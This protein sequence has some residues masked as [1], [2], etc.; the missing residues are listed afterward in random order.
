[1]V[2]GP[3]P[4]SGRACL[5]GS[6]LDSWPGR[7]CT[8]HPPP[9]GACREG[10]HGASCCLHL[11]ARR[12]CC[13]EGLP[14][15]PVTSRHHGQDPQ[16]GLSDCCCGGDK[17]G[18]GEKPGGE[19]GARGKGVPPRG[20]LLGWWLRRVWGRHGGGAGA[21]WRVPLP[22]QRW[23]VT[24]PSGKESKVTLRRPRAAPADLSPSWRGRGVLGPKSIG[25]NLPH[26][27]FPGREKPRKAPWFTL[28]SRLAGQSDD[29]DPHGAS[30]SASVGGVCSP[31]RL[32]QVCLGGWGSPS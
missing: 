1:M 7:V 23:E 19:V 21:A 16:T 26:W 4:Q 28:G 20:S 25:M 12:H 24:P 13:P 30:S 6:G 22:P 10:R 18:C 27:C 32:P 3:R 9:R 11:G 14:P 15:P 5:W 2:A 29:G 17:R 31:G 8:H